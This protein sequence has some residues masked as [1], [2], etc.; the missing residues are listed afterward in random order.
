MVNAVIAPVRYKLKPGAPWTRVD[1]DQ[2]IVPAGK[3]T[4]VVLQTE[5]SGSGLLKFFLICCKLF[6]CSNMFWSVDSI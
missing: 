6:Y 4:Q 2:A 5:Y 3:D 1:L